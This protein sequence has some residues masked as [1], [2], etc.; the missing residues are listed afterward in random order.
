MSFDILT[1]NDET[2]S[3]FEA[4]SKERKALQ[5]KGL[6]PSWYTTQAWQV[7]KDTAMV[8][9]EDA[10]LGRAKTI[11]NTI[12]KYSPDFDVWSKKFFNLIWDN[13][14][15]P[16]SPVFTNTGTNKGMPVSCSGQYVEDS[17]VSFYDNIKRMALLSKH[18]F[19][20]SM[21]F[22]AVRNRG[23]KIST[24]GKAL[25]PIPFTLQAFDTAANVSQ[26]GARRGQVNVYVDID[27]PSFD[28]A[29]DVLKR[30]PN[31][32][33]FTWTVRDSFIDK[34]VAGDEQANERF[35]NMVHTKLLTGKGLVFFV[36]KAN[37]LRP[38]MYKDNNL[39]IKQSNLC[40]EIL[41]HSSP[42]YD[43]SCILSSLNL[44]HADKMLEE[45]NTI[46]FDSMVFLDCL[47]SYF[48]D[49][50]E[51]IEGLEKVRE[52][53]IKGR[54]VGLGVM[55]LHTYFQSKRIPYASLEAQF[56]EN[57][58]FKHIHD[59]TLRASKWL[60]EVYG[61]P[62]WC[63]GY[64]VRNTHRT[65]IAPTK[66]SSLMMGGVSEGI[67]PDPGMVFDGV[68]A[69]GQLRRITPIFYEFMKEKG[70][71]NEETIS[72]I[73][74]D[75]GSCRNQDWMT[76]EEKEI[77]KNAFEY[78]QKLLLRRA[79]LRQ[80]WLCQT[81]S[82]NFYISE[83]NCEVELSEIMTLCFLNRNIPTQYYVYTRNGVVVQKDECLACHA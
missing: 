23:D 11:A 74:R 53:T 81:Q 28:E 13:Y 30:H 40:T 50:S 64:G 52:F 10:Y 80:K 19:G 1:D 47:C 15:S 9:G 56:R 48:I 70:A 77:F 63:K 32:K 33:N 62:E 83:E 36:D 75:V 3:K 54:A 2:L 61:E 18:G 59:E 37:E 46:I 58:I 42:D 51:G 78:D 65:A 26:G 79:A 55:G 14:L 29:I 21:D 68:S 73:I 39:D 31:G 17:I 38:Q 76:D 57:E 41:L 6:L 66:T 44:L 5:A 60:A 12:A 7:F 82:L 24:G 27:T 4:L 45:G 69:K 34:L 8:E 71:Y 20:T 16:A 43:F 49:V 72:S 35:K 22:T 67:N 25:G